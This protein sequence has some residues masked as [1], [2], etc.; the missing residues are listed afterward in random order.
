MAVYTSEN[1][2]IVYRNYVEDDYD[3]IRKLFIG[4]NMENAKQAAWVCYTSLK[5][6]LKV[7]LMTCV[8]YIIVDSYIGAI[9]SIIFFPL[10][11]SYLAHKTW[12]EYHHWALDSNKDLASA[13][14]AR[15]RFEEADGRLLI[16]EVEGRVVG[17]CGLINTKDNDAT[18]NPMREKRAELR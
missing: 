7:I 10:Y 5:M 17:M 12:V 15:R 13:A 14:V 8:S 9:I 4:V 3:T 2:S 1:S 11:C 18:G 16:A 6:W